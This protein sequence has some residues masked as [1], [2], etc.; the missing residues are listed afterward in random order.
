MKFVLSGTGRAGTGSPPM[1]LFINV[2]F[3][4][5]TY[6]SLI[7]PSFIVVTFSYSLLSPFFVSRFFRWRPKSDINNPVLPT[8]VCRNFPSGFLYSCLY[9]NSII[10]FWTVL[11]KTGFKK[12]YFITYHR[13]SGCRE[14]S[15][16]LRDFVDSCEAFNGHEGFEFL[17]GG[18][19]NKLRPSNKWSTSRGF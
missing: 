19:M 4:Y 13:N 8:S 11:Q 7:I 15:V 12:R 5:V 14:I 17:Y 6:F 16:W 2:M 10:W 18:F 9:K 1:L 3:Y